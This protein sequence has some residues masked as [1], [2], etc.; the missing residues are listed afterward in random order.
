MNTA[1]Q[2]A[3]FYG[4]DYDQFR[5][6]IRSA[7][8]QSRENAGVRGKSRWEYFDGYMAD[9]AA[10]VNADARAYADFEDRAYGGR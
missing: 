1:R 10:Y 4:L 2:I 8:Q 7:L 5:E 3:E 9:T 6:D